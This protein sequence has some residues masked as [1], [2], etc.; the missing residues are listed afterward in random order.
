MANK[1]D[2]PTFM[3]AIN[4]PDAA[5]FMEAMKLE[6]TTLMKMETFIIVDKEPWIKVVLAFKRKRY[7]DGSIRKLKAQFCARGF[8]QREK[9]LTIL[10]LL[11]L[12]TMAKSAS[13]S[14]YDYSYWTR[15][16]TN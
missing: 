9:V 2:D 16:Q 14:Y 12:C 8:E 5:G 3:E 7:P 13:Y 10:K 4:G 15:N 6:F 1:E 11:L